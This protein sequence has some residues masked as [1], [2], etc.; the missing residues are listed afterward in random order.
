VRGETETY[1]MSSQELHYY[2]ERWKWKTY[3]S[4]K[5]PSRI[6]FHKTHLY[7]MSKYLNNN[8]IIGKTAAA[9]AIAHTWIIFILQFHFLRT[10]FAL[11]RFHRFNAI[12]IWSGDIRCMCL[13]N[14]HTK[15]VFF[16]LSKVFF[17]TNKP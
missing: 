16:L 9:A 2:G 15:N 11:H 4:I 1:N 10:Q 12:K 14:K 8:N 5:F 13:Q 6:K 3:C 17:C 7:F